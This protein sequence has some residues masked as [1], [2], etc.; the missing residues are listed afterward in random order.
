MSE[1]YPPQ[2]R[3]GARAPAREAPIEKIEA[4]AFRIPT[5]A[6]EAD[7]TLSWDATVLVV[8]RVEAGGASGLGY[9]Y[10]D[11]A[12]VSLAQGVLLK[13]LKGEDA[14]DIPRCSIAMQRAVRNLGRSGLVAC[15]ISAVDCALWDLKARALGLP[16]ATLLGRLREAVPIYG[17]GGF[18]SY[19]D[20][21]LRDQLCGWAEGDGCRFV[22]MKV[23]SEPTRDPHRVA[24]AKSAIGDTQLFIDAN[25]AL[26]VKQALDFAEV[27]ASADIRWFEEPV[28]SDDEAGLKLVRARCDPTTEV[29]AGEYNYTTD[30]ARRLLEHDAVD[31]MQADVTRCGGVTGFLRIA[32]MCEAH[33]ID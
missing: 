20:E 4:A 26:S 6:P 11:E 21:Q 25:G 7:G 32:A 2:T 33:H 30:D 10:A 24:V 23:G 29:A 31:V 1:Q 22:K 16:L 18:T 8:V 14:F 12:V 27:C 15:A 17:S 9:T 5:D 19:S 28:S 3:P 13:T